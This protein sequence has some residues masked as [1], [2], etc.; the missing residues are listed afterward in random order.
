MAMKTDPVNVTYTQRTTGDVKA[1]AEAQ[2]ENTDAS[3]CTLAR[4]AWLV[5]D[6]LETSEADLPIAGFEVDAR[7]DHDKAAKRTAI[8]E[9]LGR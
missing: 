5:A 2:F 9:Y 8:V 3:I 7:Y 4:L 6:Q 1:L